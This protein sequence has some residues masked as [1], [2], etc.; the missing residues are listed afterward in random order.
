M[1][2]RG[3][4]L[5]LTFFVVDYF[6]VFLLVLILRMEAPP[7]SMGR[8]SNEGQ[9]ESMVLATILASVGVLPSTKTLAILSESKGTLLGESLLG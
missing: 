8:P 3:C 7:N 6:L 4:H 1:L 5:S 9:V 2:L